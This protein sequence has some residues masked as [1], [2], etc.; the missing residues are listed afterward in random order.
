[1]ARTILVTGASGNVGSQVLL[2]LAGVA[3]LEVRAGVRQPEH[4]AKSAADITPVKFAFEDADAM[5]KA[6]AGAD[7][8]FWVAPVTPNM[9]DCGDGF[10]GET[11]VVAGR[12]GIG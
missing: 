4:V 5:Q 1:M 8:V 12:R 7:A 10:A 2:K 6:C 9:Q 11:T 3:G